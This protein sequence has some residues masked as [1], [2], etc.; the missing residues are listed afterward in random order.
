MYCKPWVWAQD[1]ITSDSAVRTQY[2]HSQQ[3]VGNERTTTRDPRIRCR[4]WWLSWRPLGNSNMQ[5]QWNMAN[6]A[7]CLL[8]WALV[9]SSVSCCALRWTVPETSLMWQQGGSLLQNVERILN[10][11][12]FLFV[13]LDSAHA[14]LLLYDA[15]SAA[16]IA[17]DRAC[18]FPPTP[19]WPCTGFWFVFLARKHVHCVEE[20]HILAQR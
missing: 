15:E 19:Q 16:Q 5:L 4:C 2:V 12:V 8:C 10:A 17:E 9:W 13:V 7:K 11:A 18:T 1:T 20:Q 14:Y 3:G 6:S